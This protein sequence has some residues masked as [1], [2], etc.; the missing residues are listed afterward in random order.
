MFIKGRV[1]EE[2]RK[3]FVKIVKYVVPVLSSQQ[4]ERGGKY[5]VSVDISNGGM[6]IITDFPL[7]QGQ[8]LTFEKEIPINALISKRA[9][10]V[11]WAEKMNDK[12]RAGLK[13]V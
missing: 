4:R 9:A 12:Y 5:A 8:S 3:S 2:E 7:E 13:F 6:G 1:R 11:K 10:V